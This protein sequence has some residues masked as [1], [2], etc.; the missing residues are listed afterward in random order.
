LVGI[1]EVFDRYLEVT[2]YLLPKIN[3]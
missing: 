1:K 3:L 2:P